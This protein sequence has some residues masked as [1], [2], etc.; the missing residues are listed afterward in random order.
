MSNKQKMNI[1]ICGDPECNLTLTN[2]L[3]F[4]LGGTLMDIIICRRNILKKIKEY[5]N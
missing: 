5:L 3:K 2:R 4:E 1:L